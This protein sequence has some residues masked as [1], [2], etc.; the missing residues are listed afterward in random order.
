LSVT[1]PEAGEGEGLA[2][3]ACDETM[4]PIKAAAAAA[5]P[6]RRIARRV[7]VA[8]SM[9]APFSSLVSRGASAHLARAL[10]CVGR[11]ARHV[12]RELPQAVPA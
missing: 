12:R 11:A 1:F 10:L 3:V 4:P 2:A 6:M 9:L 5:A 7:H 8:R